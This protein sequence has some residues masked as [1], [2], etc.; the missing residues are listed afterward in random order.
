MRRARPAWVWVLVALVFG[1]AAPAALRADE[2]AD[3]EDIPAVK[4]VDDQADAI[5][6]A[7]RVDLPLLDRADRV[8]IEESKQAGGRRV[9]LTKR[10][11]IRELAR[12][13]KTRAVAPSGGRT[14][15]TLRFYRGERLVRKV[16][17][18]EDGEWGFE[19]PGTS[20]TTGRER[21]LWK[22]IQKRL[23]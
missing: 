5:R 4:K 14:A 13:L 18:F 2:P 1:V 12:T 9:T 23:R 21:E 7:R 17:V 22:V 6:E 15:V 16:W 10:E 3:A 8:V 20:W 11:R 19:R